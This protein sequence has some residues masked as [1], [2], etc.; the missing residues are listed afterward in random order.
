MSSFSPSGPYPGNQYGNQHGNP[1]GAP[2]GGLPNRPSYPG[3]PTQPR[4][5][6]QKSRGSQ[7]RLGL[8][9]AAGY[10]ALIWAVHIYQR[11]PIWWRLNRVWHPSIGHF[12][13]ALHFH[14]T[15]PAR[16]F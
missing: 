12:V 10:V 3:Q 9:Y 16:K 15:D 14:L 11:V 13:V 7:M 1:Y 8:V 5:P 2:Y 6:R 4:H